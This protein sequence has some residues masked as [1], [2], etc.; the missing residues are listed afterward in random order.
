MKKAILSSIF[1]LYSINI[2]GQIKIDTMINNKYLKF[3]LRVDRKHLVSLEVQNKT[4]DTLF[5][6]TKL[7]IEQP[8]KLFYIAGY[9]KSN[10]DKESKGSVYYRGGVLWYHCGCVTNDTAYFHLFGKSGKF[11]EKLPPKTKI[12]VPISYFSRG[13]Y[14]FKI[15]TVYVYRKKTYFV[16][17]ETN[18]IKVE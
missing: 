4:S 7:E 3:K 2:F 6:R 14:F 13:K 8:K 10:E 17:T 16:R 9:E 15:Q 11:L 18:K 5:V 12:I 1:M